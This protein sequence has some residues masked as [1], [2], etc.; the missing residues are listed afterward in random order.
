MLG[1][2]ADF[3]A[4]DTQ[5]HHPLMLRG[6]GLQG[7]L[8]GHLQEGVVGGLALQ[9]IEPEIRPITLCRQAHVAL[10]GG[11]KGPGVA[12]LVEGDDEQDAPQLLAGRNV[13][14]A[15]AG[16]LKEAAKNRLHYVVGI[17][18][19]RQLG[20]A[21]RPRQGA[22]ALGIAHIKFGRSVFAARA[23][24]AHQRAVGKLGSRRRGSFDSGLL[25]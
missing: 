16:G 20:R 7:F 19:R 22:Y 21:A 10:G 25:Q 23:E 13:V 2:L 5:L 24:A 14:V 11:V 18:P 8:D 1:D 6:Q 15:L 4:L 3:I 12:N 17:H 9:M